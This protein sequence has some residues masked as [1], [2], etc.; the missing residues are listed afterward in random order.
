MKVGD[1]VKSGLKI[2]PGLGSSL[3]ISRIPEGSIIHNISIKPNTKSKISR[4]AGT[5]SVLRKKYTNFAVIKL[6]SGKLKNIPLKCFATIG[7]VSNENYYFTQNSKA[8]HS[9]WMNKRPTV[10]GVAMNPI[11]HPH[12]GGE[13][14]KSG[15]RYTPWGKPKKKA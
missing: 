6:S 8:G 14:K 12:G 3:P 11:D 7:E 1:I 10:R 9:R 5:F 4:S 2:E 15:K 13:G